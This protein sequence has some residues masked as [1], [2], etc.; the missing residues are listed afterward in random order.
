MP[1]VWSSVAELDAT[2]QERLADVLETRGADPQQQAMRRVFLT[3]IA[4]PAGAHVL[5]V[6]C[7]TGVLTR[8]LARWPEVGT[9]VGVDC[10]P[11]L[12]DR[13]RG[14]TADL[15]NVSFQEGDGRSLPLGRER[16][17]PSSSTR[18]CLTCRIPNA[19]SPRR[20]GF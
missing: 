5:E 2:T 12:L 9:V 4:F 14:L 19:R 6:G 3:D 8:T 11:S 7:G 16:S 10:A 17:M 18:H 15:P 13:A 1:D 20:F